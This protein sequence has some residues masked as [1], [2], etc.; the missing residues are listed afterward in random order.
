MHK[1]NLKKAHRILRTHDQQTFSLDGWLDLDIKFDGKSLNTPV[2]ITCVDAQDQLLLSEGV[3]KQLGIIS[4]HRDVHPLK[5]LVKDTH[6]VR[7]TSEGLEAQVPLVRIH[8][9]Q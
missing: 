5:Q 6:S 9:V 4:N 2:Y 7:A 1:K 8:L 3:S